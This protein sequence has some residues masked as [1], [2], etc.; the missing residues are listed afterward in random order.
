MSV[1]EYVGW[2]DKI[3]NFRTVD[4][5]R[6][7]SLPLCDVEPVLAAWDDMLNST[8]RRTKARSKGGHDAF[9][10]AASQHTEAPTV[11]AKGTRIRVYWTGLQKWYHATVQSTK[12]AKDENNEKYRVT[13]VLYDAADGW[14]TTADLTYTHCLEDID[15]TLA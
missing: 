10:V 1:Q 11:L 2:I 7:T 14:N 4:A 9:D 8:P 6:T 15:W 12:T 5:T 3:M 13:R